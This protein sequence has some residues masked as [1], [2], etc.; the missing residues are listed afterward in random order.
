MSSID[1]G[2]IQGKPPTGIEAPDQ[3]G[4]TQNQQSAYVAETEEVIDIGIEGFSYGEVR[5]VD[6]GGKGSGKEQS[7]RG[8]HQGNSN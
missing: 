6:R 8:V 4:K 1:Q 3:S 2:N 5:R 7:D